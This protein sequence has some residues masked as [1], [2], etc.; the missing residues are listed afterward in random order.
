MCTN[1]M[2]TSAASKPLY[3]SCTAVGICPFSDAAAKPVLMLNKRDHR[4][5]IR[6]SIREK[7]LGMSLS[8]CALVSPNQ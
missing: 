8:S 3:P 1:R 6:S 7:D 4:S 5:R 2:K